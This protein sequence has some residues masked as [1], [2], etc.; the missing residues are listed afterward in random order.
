MRWNENSFKSG[1]Y[2]R[3]KKWT[4]CFLAEEVQI[5]ESFK[6]INACN[7]ALLL[8]SEQSNHCFASDKEKQ[9]P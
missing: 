1:I 8:V 6:K 4:A 9:F 7:L 3:F 2:L 5:R